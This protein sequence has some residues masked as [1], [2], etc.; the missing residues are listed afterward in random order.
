MSTNEIK[1][2]EICNG[3]AQ[4]YRV[5]HRGG[6]ETIK[7]VYGI[8]EFCVFPNG[9]W[10]VRVEEKGTGSTLFSR[11][12]ESSDRVTRGKKVLGIVLYKNIS[13]T[14]DEDVYIQCDW[15]LGSPTSRAARRMYRGLPKG[16]KSPQFSMSMLTK[17]DSCPFF[18]AWWRWNDQVAPGKRLWDDGFGTLDELNGVVRE[19]FGYHVD[20]FDRTTMKFPSEEWLRSDE[21][22]QFGLEM[23][24]S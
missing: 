15:P 5:V 19:P 2:Y 17:N 12:G 6:K 20:F 21:P 8:A 24:S 4:G 3:E 10:Y 16:K 9:S 11:E 7:P 18:I 13:G 1:G 14:D 22:L 23:D